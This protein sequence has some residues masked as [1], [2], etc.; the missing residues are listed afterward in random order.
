MRRLVAVAAMLVLGVSCVA[1][2]KAEVEEGFV[3]IFDGKTLEGWKASGNA[4]SWSARDGMLCAEGPR[5]HL[6]YVGEVGK[7]DFK[8]FELKAEVMTRRG[9]NSGIYFHTKWQD[10]GWPGQGFECQVNNT[11]GDWK[12][13]GSLYNIVNVRKAPAKDDVWFTYHITVAGK[14]VTIQ[15][16]GKTV[17]EYT[18]PANAKRK[19]S[20]GTIALQAHDPKS[21][22]YYRN[23]RIKPLPE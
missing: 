10:R 22:V 4:K 20:S 12:K 5:S 23:L 16:D 15:I 8:N 6:F 18:E 11:H 21:R 19:L 7:A 2:E 3:S 17:M 13:T 9:S 14:A 1:A